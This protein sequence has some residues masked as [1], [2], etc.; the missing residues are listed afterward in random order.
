MTLQD[1]LR[2]S[3][4]C[5]TWLRT[6]QNQRQGP[7]FQQKSVLPLWAVKSLGERLCFASCLSLRA[8]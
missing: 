3:V 4:A 7:V 2:N 1:A 8:E 5:I 6:C